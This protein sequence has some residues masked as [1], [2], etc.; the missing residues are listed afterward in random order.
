MLIPETIETPTMDDRIRARA[1]AL[2]EDD[3]GPHGLSDHYWRQARSD[4]ESE[5]AMPPEDG[6]FFA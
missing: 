2:W 3:G 5:D 6:T 4:L 1:Y